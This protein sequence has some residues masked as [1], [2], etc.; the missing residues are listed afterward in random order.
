MEVCKILIVDEDTDNVGL[1][2]EA[3]QKVI[4]KVLIMCTQQSR[5]YVLAG[6]KGERRTPK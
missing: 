5:V 2:T 3:L 6:S 4:L 1:L